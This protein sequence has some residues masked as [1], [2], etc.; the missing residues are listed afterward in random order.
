M[1]LRV[2]T[3]LIEG[4]RY[5]LKMFGVSIDGATSV[6]C[7][8]QSVTKNA[9]VPAST[10]SK[11]HNSICYHMVRESVASSWISVAW[12]KSQNNLADLF[13]KVCPE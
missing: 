1:T 3:E 10:L 9:T 7:D 2:G 12:I 4:L 11:K 5:K 13:N 8:N 6:Y